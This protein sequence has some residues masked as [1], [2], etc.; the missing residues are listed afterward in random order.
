MNNKCT[1]L[2]EIQFKLLFSRRKRDVDEQDDNSVETIYPFLE[3]INKIGWGNLNEVSCQ[4]VSL[5]MFI[6]IAVD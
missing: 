1:N 5:S 6:A 3:K 2:L 4:K